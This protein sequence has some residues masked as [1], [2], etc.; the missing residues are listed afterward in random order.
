V[1]EEGLPLRGSLHHVRFARANG[2]FS[3]RERQQAGLLAERLG[4]TVQLA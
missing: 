4:L 3:A 2:A 1:R